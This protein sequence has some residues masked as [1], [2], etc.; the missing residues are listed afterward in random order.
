[1]TRFSVTANADAVAL[2]HVPYVLCADFDFASG[3]I[4]LNSYDRDFSFSGNTY[5]GLGQLVGIGPI[6]ESA[7]LSADKLDFSLSHV[8]NSTMSTTLTQTYHGRSASLY[9]GYLNDSLALVGTPHLLWEGRMDSLKVRSE[10]GGSIINLVC[11]N[12]L[13][14]WNKASG[15]LWTHEHQREF[16][17]DDLIFDQVSSLVNKVAKWGEET[18]TTG[19]TGGPPGRGGN[20]FYEQ[21]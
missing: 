4:R 14:L 9:V 7:D 21:P 17:P 13:M 16:D 19:R 2:P 6:K 1:V 10:E 15:W 11:E 3:H 8:P 5:T 20:V 18:V 12:R